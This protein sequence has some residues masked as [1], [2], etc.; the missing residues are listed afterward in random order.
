MTIG[1]L[2]RLETPDGEHLDVS[3]ITPKRRKQW[4]ETLL[5]DLLGLDGV[6]EVYVAGYGPNNQSALLELV[7]DHSAGDWGEGVAI[8][9]NLRSLSPRLRNTIRETWCVSSVTVE[10]TPE[11]LGGPNGQYDAPFYFIDVDFY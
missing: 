6:S 9:A 1:A 5:D 8:E 2:T 3:D 11:S 4:C 7:V 10:S